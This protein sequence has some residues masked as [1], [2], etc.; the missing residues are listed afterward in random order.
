MVSA[1][2]RMV[3]TLLI[4]TDE[5]Y[6]GRCATARRGRCGSPAPHADHAPRSRGRPH[7]GP[8]GRRDRRRAA[9]D[10]PGEVAVLRLRGELSRPC[11]RRWRSPAAEPSQPRRRLRPQSGLGMARV[12]GSTSAV[13]RSAASRTRRPPRTSGGE[14]AP[15]EGRLPPGRHRPGVDAAHPVA[16]GA[17]PRSWTSR[18]GGLSPRRPCRAE[19]G[20]PSAILAASRGSRRCLKCAG[21]PWSTSEGPRHH[22]VRDR[23]PLHC[24]GHRREPRP[25]GDGR[26]RPA[27]A[28][29]ARLP[30]RTPARRSS[31]SRRAEELRRLD[32]GRGLRRRHHP[33][34]GALPSCSRFFVI[35]MPRRSRS[36]AAGPS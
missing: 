18:F 22:R 15:A 25:T 10:G 17:S 32:P 14:L 31:R 11:E 2:N 34:G 30:G 24:R 26:R 13:M 23:G 8:A 6:P 9:T 3:L 4:L 20:N 33:P 36:P 29:R 16:F 28:G 19:E 21:R 12:R 1:G 35:P 5:E 27:Q 7:A